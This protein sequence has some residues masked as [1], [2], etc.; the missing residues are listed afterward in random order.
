MIE[1]NM[2]ETISNHIIKGNFEAVLL[3]NGLE[4]CSWPGVTEQV[5][6]LMG[7]NVEPLQISET[8]L[9]RSMMTFMGKYL[10]NEFYL[11]DLVDKAKCIS[12]ARNVLAESMGDATPLPKGKAVLAAVSNEGPSFWR[13]TVGILLNGLGFDTQVLS[14]RDSLGQMIQSIETEAPDLLGIAV[15]TVVGIPEATPLRAATVASAVKM[16]INALS[17]CGN[18]ENITVMVGGNIPGIQ[19][20]EALGAD[21]YCADFTETVGA[22]YKLN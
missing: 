13:D 11:P 14:G 18:R 4:A 6:F 12:K 21:Y 1:E 2:L 22:L 16:T 3:K 20:A 8:V 7:K 17:Q 9:D 19:S 15:P 10:K 5:R